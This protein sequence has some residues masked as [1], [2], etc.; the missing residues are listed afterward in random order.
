MTLQ[1][2]YGLYK[3]NTQNLFSFSKYKEVFYSNFNLTEKNSTKIP[4]IFATQ[5]ANKLV[6]PGMRRRELNSTMKKKS[7]KNISI[8][9][10][11]ASWKYKKAQDN[12][13]NE[14]FTFNL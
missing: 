5:S 4:A 8:G 12:Q 14:T 1:V 7:S 6:T 2:M 3:I 9:Q 10:K 13:T 11:S